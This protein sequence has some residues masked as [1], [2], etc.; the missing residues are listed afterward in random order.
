[1]KLGAAT[2]TPFG[3]QLVESPFAYRPLSTIFNIIWVVFFGAAIALTHIAHAIPLFMS[4]IGIPFG[5]QHI[6]LV[7]LALFPFGRDLQ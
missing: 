1:M 4:I 5:I 6:K 2:M 3:K 7:P